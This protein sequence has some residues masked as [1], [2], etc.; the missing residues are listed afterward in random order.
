MV[1]RVTQ[2]IQENSL[3]SSTGFLGMVLQKMQLNGHMKE[4]HGVKSGRVLSTRTSIP[5]V[6]VHQLNYMAHGCIHKHRISETH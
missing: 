2:E 4:E 6:R 1:A 5:S 3:L